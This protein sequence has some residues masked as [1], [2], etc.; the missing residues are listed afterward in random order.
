MIMRAFLKKIELENFRG[1][2]QGALEFDELTLLIGENGSGKSTFMD[3]LALCIGAGASET[4]FGFTENDLNHDMPFNPL[5]IVITFAEE[6]EFTLKSDEEIDV[7][8]FKISK[9]HVRSGP[10]KIKGILETHWWFSDNNRISFASDDVETL[11]Q[12]R[13]KFPFYL[14]RGGLVL[15]T[16]LSEIIAKDETA[17]QKLESIH[18]LEKEIEHHYQ[19]LISDNLFARHS[20]LPEAVNKAMHF[21]KHGKAYLKG[22]GLGSGGFLVE[23]IPEYAKNSTITAFDKYRNRGSGAQQIAVLLF[24]GAFLE[25]RKSKITEGS[26]PILAIENPEAHLHP[27]TVAAVMELIDQLSWQKIISTHSGQ[28]AS[29]SPLSS[30]RRLERRDGVVSVYRAY[31]ESLRL[32]DLRRVSYHI[33]SRNGRALFARTWLLVEGET[34]FWLLPELAHLCGYDL[35]M[36]GIICIEYAQCGVPALLKLANQLDIEWHLIADGD[37]A[38]ITYAQLAE[39]FIQETPRSDQITLL[40]EKDIEHCFW[41]YGY[42]EVFH[43]H[44]GFSKRQER[45][46]KGKDRASTV[47]R[48]A[49]D[50]HSKPFMALALLEA[51]SQPGSPGVPAPLKTAIEKVIKLARNP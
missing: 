3:A 10:E 30:I 23:L 26:F 1:I 4:G 7:K 45:L 21:L 20:K 18:D 15:P 16:S 19:Q 40:K 25:A 48:S 43:R 51:A 12:L 13:Q 8:A 6:D 41:E 5:K 17:D 33:R 36:E 9:L 34:E 32:E 22:S 44:S 24:L 2:Q 28:V 42:S 27:L 50:L 46:P 37:R 49:I 39:Q 35:E 29:I 11:N 47:I 14:M 31:P 38:G